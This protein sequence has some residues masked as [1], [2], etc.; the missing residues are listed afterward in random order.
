MNK[1]MD[2]KE[3]AQK[4]QVSIRT[5]YGWI[6]EG[7]I[8]TVKIGR[9]VRFKIEDIEAWIAKNTR[10]GRTK[11]VPEITSKRQRL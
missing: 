6:S 11:Y 4:L 8:P 3:V 7:S 10:K 2:A 5:V 1:L 9:L